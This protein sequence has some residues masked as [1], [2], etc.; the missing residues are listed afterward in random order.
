MIKKG[1]SQMVAYID[2]ISRANAKVL[3][4]VIK[5][6]DLT[7]TLEQ[8][9]EEVGYAAR[10]EARGEELGAIKIAKNMIAQGLPF[11]TIVTSTQLEPE[12]VKAL[13]Q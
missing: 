5:M 10:W 8:V 12:K 9:F 11:E 2:A 4:E 6:S 13:Y 3:R 7:V 1:G